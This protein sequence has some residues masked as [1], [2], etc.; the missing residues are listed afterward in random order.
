M[1][2]RFS[3]SIANAENDERDDDEDH[4][5]RDDDER[6][7]PNRGQNPNPRHSND[8]REFQT[9][10]KQRKKTQ[11]SNAGFFHFHSSFSVNAVFPSFKWNIMASLISSK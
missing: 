1:P 5:R 7:N 2:C 9:D 10:E 6:R 11:K 8:A 4:K 3:L